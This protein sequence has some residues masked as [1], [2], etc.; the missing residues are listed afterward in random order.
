MSNDIDQVRKYIK[1]AAFKIL[2]KNLIEALIDVG[3][4]YAVGMID[5]QM[6]KQSVPCTIKK[7]LALSLTLGLKLL[8]GWF[9]GSSLHLI[10]LMFIFQ[11]LVIT[12]IKVFKP[13]KSCQSKSLM[14]V[15]PIA[16]MSVEPAKLNEVV[17]TLLEEIKS[18]V[19]RNEKKLDA[20]FNHPDYQ[21]CMKILEKINYKAII[22]R[23]LSSFWC[24]IFFYTIAS[25]K[26]TKL[27]LLCKYLYF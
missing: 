15:E 24:A 5:E 7:I 9:L 14:S 6:E 16:L 20:P 3:I 17:A 1:S 4:E 8:F 22:Q 2:A 13:D 11:N 10:V 18:D 26:K 25:V 23:N 21:K 19:R 27:K 12:V